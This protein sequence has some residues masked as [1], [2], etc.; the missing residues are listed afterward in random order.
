MATHDNP[1]TPEIDYSRLS[2]LPANPFGQ[3]VTPYPGTEALTGPQYDSGLSGA[4]ET[5]PERQKQIEGLMTLTTSFPIPETLEY[6][7]EGE[8]SDS[9]APPAQAQGKI[10][11]P[12]MPPA[13]I[14]LYPR[15][16]IRRQPNKTSI[17]GFSLEQ[18]VVHQIC[19]NMPARYKSKIYNVGSTLGSNLI[20]I[21]G[22]EDEAEA[23]CS[24]DASQAVNGFPLAIDPAGGYP[25]EHES[26]APLWA[27][28]T[29]TGGS[30]VVVCTDFYDFDGNN[31]AIASNTLSDN[32]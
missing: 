22:T 12:K 3:K 2:T 9:P 13:P 18:N 19:S 4:P 11:A 25:Y 21:C 10:N 28:C 29:V 20:Y 14:I 7:L 16:T 24:T 32:F 6:P 15:S 23:L 17:K 30:F 1:D 27:V 26:T 5:L 31:K 8:S